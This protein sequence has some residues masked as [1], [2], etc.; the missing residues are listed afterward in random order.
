MRILACLTAVAALA[1]GCASHVARTSAT[2]TQSLYDVVVLDGVVMDPESGLDAVRN[3]GILDGAVQSIT[4]EPIHGRTSVDARGLVVAPGFIDLNLQTHTPAALRARSLDG[5]TCISITSLG[6]H[7]LSGGSG[8]A[9]LFAIV[10]TR[11][12]VPIR[13]RTV[14]AE[15]KVPHGGQ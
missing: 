11:P 8:R 6:F 9:P 2:P 3:I 14:A 13:S 4:T 15:V 10:G 1:A 5:V 7:R 12:P